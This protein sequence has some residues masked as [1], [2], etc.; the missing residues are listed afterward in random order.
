MRKIYSK[1][2]RDRVR[3]FQIETYIAVEDGNKYVAKR[4]LNTDAVNHIEKM[5]RFYEEHK[6]T[7]LYCG[8]SLS[9]TGTIRFDFLEGKSLCK[10]MLG[11]LSDKDEASFVTYLSTYKE[12]LKNCQGKM[13]EVNSAKESAEEFKEVFGEW[14]FKNPMLCAKNLDIDLTFDNIIHAEDTGSYKVIDYEWF[15]PFAVPVKYVIYR[16]VF[17]F[18]FKYASMMQDVIDLHQIYELFEISDEEIKLFEEMNAHFDA[19]AYGTY[20]MHQVY[21]KYKKEVY[22]VR[23]LLPEEHLFLQMF[24]NDGAEYREDMA[25]TVPLDTKQVDVTI[26]VK[27]QENMHANALIYRVDPLNVSCVLKNLKIYVM[28]KDGKSAKVEQFEHNAVLFSENRMAFPSEDPQVLIKNIWN[29]KVAALHV[30][31]EILQAG[32]AEQPVMRALEE[33][34][35]E[36]CEMPEQMRKVQD[37]LNLI[38]ASKVYQSLLAKK[39]DKLMGDIYS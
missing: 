17:A 34:Q 29:K 22:N 6:D 33:K 28:F 38:K 11:A 37:E 19:Y 32:M 21:D 1:L 14:S 12:I 16:A 10:E 36:L 39:I 26:P 7:G 35:K 4:A 25:V 20:G 30:R 27:E 31:F 15:F 2:T 23:K 5:H 8:S 18:H 3:K 24:E 13:E 9:K